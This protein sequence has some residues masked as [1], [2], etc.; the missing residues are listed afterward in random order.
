MYGDRIRTFVSISSIVVRVFARCGRLFVVL[1]FCSCDEFLRRVKSAVGLDIAYV[2]SRALAI[3]VESAF[4]A[5]VMLTPET[6][7]GLVVN[8]RSP[9]RMNFPCANF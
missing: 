7:G 6:S 2:T 5:K 3:M 9:V 4:L 8:A 1:H